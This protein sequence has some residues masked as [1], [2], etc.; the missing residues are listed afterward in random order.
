MILPPT[1]SWRLGEPNPL[2][3]DESGLIEQITLKLHQN[4]VWLSGGEI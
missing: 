1:L 4:A 3:F 2:M